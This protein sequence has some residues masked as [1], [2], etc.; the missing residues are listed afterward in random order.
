MFSKTREEYYSREN[1]QKEV[2]AQ[3]LSFNGFA[4]DNGFKG[5]KQ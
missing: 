1:N 4:Q 3:I 5:S 2:L